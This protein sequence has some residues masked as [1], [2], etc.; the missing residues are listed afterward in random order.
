MCYSVQ[1]RDWIFVKG[2]GFLSFA[3]NVG[4]NIGKSISK[5]LSGK[6]SQ[7]RLDVAKQSVTNGFRLALNRAIQKTAEANGDLIGNKIANEITKVS[8]NS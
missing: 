3:K 4:N 1:R 6:Y 8:K 2:Y 7:E 5:N